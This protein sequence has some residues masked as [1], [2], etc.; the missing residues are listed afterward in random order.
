MP[1]WPIR[2]AS[3]VSGVLTG[4]SDGRRMSFP[5]P[6]LPCSLQTQIPSLELS[7]TEK[8]NGA[9]KTEQLFL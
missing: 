9:L 4:Q 1:Q 2:A 7:T 5:S 3:S 8:L 6:T